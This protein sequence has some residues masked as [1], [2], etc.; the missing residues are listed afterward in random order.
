MKTPYSAA[1]LAATVGIVLTGC[2][3]SGTP[4]T[5]PKNGGGDAKAFVA[6]VNQEL[7]A[8]NRE[9]NAA[10]WVQSSSN[11]IVTSSRG[12]RVFRQNSTTGEHFATR[13]DVDWTKITP[14]SGAVK[15]QLAERQYTTGG[16]PWAGQ[17]ATDIVMSAGPAKGTALL[18]MIDAQTMKV[19]VF[20]G[21]TPAQVSDFTSAAKTYNRGQDAHMIS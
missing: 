3:G 14:A 2:S 21:K 18:Q 1:A 10:G 8:L 15:V 20:V 5:D 12:S 4:T 11:F 16:K 9:Y 17:Y 6:S 7:V 13:G 19:E